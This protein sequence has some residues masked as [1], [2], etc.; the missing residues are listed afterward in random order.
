MVKKAGR[1]HYGTGSITK[2]VGVWDR[3]IVAMGEGGV[4]K[5]GA[6]TG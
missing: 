6:S 4:F 3:Q 2:S 1:N 5:A